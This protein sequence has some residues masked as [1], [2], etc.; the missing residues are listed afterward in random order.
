VVNL[1]ST[2]PISFGVKLVTAV[3][4]SSARK[5]RSS[6]T[7]WDS[8]QVPRAIRDPFMPR[9]VEVENSGKMR[10]DRSVDRIGTIGGGLLAF[11]MLAVHAAAAHASTLAHRSRWVSGTRRPQR[12]PALADCP[13]STRHHKK[14]APSDGSMR[15]AIN[16]TECSCRNRH[17][18]IKGQETSRQAMRRSIGARAERCLGEKFSV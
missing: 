14:Q 9:I 5:A 15:F 18:P 7:D 12:R 10:T 1:R 4:S 3:N 11:A 17:G 16:L 13:N 6:A 2:Q 8:S